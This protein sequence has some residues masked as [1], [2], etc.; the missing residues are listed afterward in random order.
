MS[1][2]RRVR[3]P[4]KL[5]A[6]QMSSWREGENTDKTRNGQTLTVLS[7]NVGNYTR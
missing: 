3:I 2:P 7:V 4:N 6:G 5:C 1:D